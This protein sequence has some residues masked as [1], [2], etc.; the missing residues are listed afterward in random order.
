MRI[1]AFRMNSEKP[2][3]GGG[4]EGDWI[5]C[6]KQVCYSGTPPLLTPWD[7]QWNP[8]IAYTLGH[9]VEPL[10]CLHLGTYMYM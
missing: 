6:G 2:G 8:S 5:N 3:G 4:G 10:H 1:A 7:I 9:T